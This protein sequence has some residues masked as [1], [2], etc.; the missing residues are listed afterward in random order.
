LPVDC[1]WQDK[2]I[3]ESAPKLVVVPRHTHCHRQAPHATP[4]ASSPFPAGK[5]LVEQ[6][7]PIGTEL[8]DQRGKTHDAGFRRLEGADDEEDRNRRPR[9]SSRRAHP[10]RSPAVYCRCHTR[11]PAAVIF[12]TSRSKVPLVG[13][14]AIVTGSADTSVGSD[15]N[16]VPSAPSKMFL[17]HERAR[18]IEL[19]DE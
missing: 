9:P 3:L 6:Q 17:P 2:R 10:R 12:K 16:R 8:D 11:V 15:G 1:K 13:S 4:A 19:D 7:I 14:R 5:L 18:R